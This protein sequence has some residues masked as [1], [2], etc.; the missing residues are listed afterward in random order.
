[1]IL[2]LPM[3]KLK[4]DTENST[5]KNSSAELNQT[6]FENILY[7]EFMTHLKTHLPEL[8]MCGVQLLFNQECDLK[9]ATIF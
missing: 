8:K 5:R 7:A 9:Y 6:N 3:S 1:M 4:P 2:C